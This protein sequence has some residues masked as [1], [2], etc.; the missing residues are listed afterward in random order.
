MYIN[1]LSKYKILLANLDKTKTQLQETK[2]FSLCVESS[3]GPCSVSLM[4]TASTPSPSIETSPIFLG[5][6]RAFSCDPYGTSSGFYRFT[7][8]TYRKNSERTMK[9]TRKFGLFGI[10]SKYKSSSRRFNSSKFLQADE[11]TTD[12]NMGPEEDNNLDEDTNELFS[13]GDFPTLFIQLPS[14]NS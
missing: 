13:I 1:Y 3:I 12:F 6:P 9:K 7:S 14:M 4:N 10:C 8:R 2:N 11:P 5:G